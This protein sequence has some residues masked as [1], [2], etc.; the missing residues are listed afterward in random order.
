MVRCIV[1]FLLIVLVLVI[2]C[3]FLSCLF[4]GSLQCCVWSPFYFLNISCIFLVWGYNVLHI[5]QAMFIEVYFKFIHKLK[6][7]LKALTFWLTP[8]TFFCH[9][10]L[11]L[12][13]VCVYP[14]VY[15]SD[16]MWYFSSSLLIF[17][18]AL[19]WVDPL[20]LIRVSLRQGEF[21]GDIFL[22]AGLIFF[23]FF[24]MKSL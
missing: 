20:L 14:I 2:L 21:C 18:L 12:F 10:F 19:V 9:C 8:F 15:C 23:F 24:L 3:C 22:F 1:D 7:V 4:D 16:C 17:A 5:Y 13:C 11:L 6:H